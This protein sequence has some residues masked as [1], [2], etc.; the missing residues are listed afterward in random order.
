MKRRI[1]ATLLAGFILVSALPVTGAGA[2]QPESEQGHYHGDIKYEPWDGGDKRN[3]LPTDGKYYYL[4]NDIIRNANGS[5]VEITEEVAQHLCLNGHTITHCNPAKRLYDIEGEF[6]LEDCSENHEEGGI[7]YGGATPST[8]SFGNCFSIQRGGTMVMTGGQIF[9]F[10]SNLPAANNSVPIFVQGAD[11]TGRAVFSMLGG[12]I[13]SNSANADSAAIRLEK[14]MVNPATENLSQVNISGGKIWGNTGSCTIAANG[15]E[16]NITGG[17]ITGNYA[18]HSAVSVAG[19]CRLAICADVTIW[20]NQGGNLHLDG[21]T[22]I[23]LGVMTGGKIGIGASKTGRLISTPR[24]EDYSSFFASDDPELAVRYQ[25]NCLYLGASHIH[26]L[27]GG[28]ENINWIKWTDSSSLPT[29]TGNYYLTGDVQL[30]EMMLLPEDQQVNLCLNGKTVTAAQDRRIMTISKGAKLRITDCCDRW[31]TITGG[32]EEY[33]GAFY[34]LSGGELTLY[35]GIIT[36]NDA[37]KEGGAIYLQSNGGMFYMYGGEITGNTADRGGAVMMAGEN[38]QAYLYGGTIWGNTAQTDAGGVFV[39]TILGVQG[40]PVVKENKGNGRNSNIFLAQDA[41]I[42]AGKLENTAELFVSA[43]TAGRAITTALEDTAAASCFYS[44]SGNWQTET[45]GTLVYLFAVNRHDHCDCSGDAAACDHKLVSWYGWEDLNTLPEK[46]GWYYLTGDVILTSRMVVEAGSEIHLCLNGYTVTAPEN[47][48]LIQI[49]GEGRLVLTDCQSTGMLTG[50][51]KTFGGAVSVLCGGV[52]DMYGGKICDNTAG[53][54]KDG[55]GGAVYLQAGTTTETGGIA[56]IHGGELTG[57]SGYRGGAVYAD[58]YSRLLVNNVQITDN[59]AGNGG[60]VYMRNA[61]ADF[62]G[63]TL[64]G[65]KAEKSGGGLF[66]TDTDIH[67]GGTDI[68]NNEAGSNGGGVYI[69]DGT[70]AFTDG[71]FSN[72]T[73]GSHGGGWYLHDAYVTVEKAAVNGNFAK[74]G[75]GGIYAEGGKLTLQKD[76][77]IVSNSTE[78]SGGGVCATEL[79]QLTVDGAVFEKNIAKSGAGV[80]IGNGATAILNDPV[81]CQNQAGTGAGLYISSNVKVTVNNGQIKGNI[82]DNKGAGVCLHTAA[83]TNSGESELYLNG[84]AIQEN[85]A[86]KSG[87]G[88]YLDKRMKLVMDNCQVRN[89][90]AGGEGAGVFQNEDSA[91]SVKNTVLTGN[92]GKAAGS[93]LYTDGA[94]LLDGCTITGNMTTDGAAVHVASFRYKDGAYEDRS[95][96]LGGNLR[97]FENEGTRKGDLYFARGVK[98]CGTD[99]GFG[100]D[101]YI[102]IQIYSGVLTEVLLAAYDYEGSD[103]VYTITYGDRSLQKEEKKTEEKKTKEK[104]QKE[105]KEKEKEYNQTKEESQTAEKEKKQAKTESQTPEKEKTRAVVVELPS[106]EYSPLWWLPAF[107]GMCVLAGG[108]AVVLLLI[109]KK[110]EKK[111]KT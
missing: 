107:W 80:L 24:D 27:D 95:I 15:D 86:E 63:G 25:D 43:Q 19:D 67:F 28:T 89:N 45:D 68:K 92:A 51:N 12:Q 97:I 96:Q 18:K 75:S 9:G 66:V 59:T 37:A 110:S 79:C 6:Y 26:G 40:N 100:K 76:V 74:K 54:T 70:A 44:D 33:G 61:S 101:T 35:Q 36:G 103:R 42:A 69:T 32:R 111:N 85:V 104:E 81:I 109:K 106:P 8:N 78:E 48:R 13:H 84:T 4:T 30:T 71:E 14:A 90:T 17:V 21:D 34:V 94:L 52:L 41:V 57:N 20:D 53:L 83:R 22:I 77:Q 65:N 1:V 31:G 88:I 5:T 98:A 2:Q 55:L 99:E 10:C 72:N 39:P 108:C 3:A 82:A 73:S 105:T 56:H 38:A 16:L 23:H 50:G 29:E 102:Q 7:T 11:S 93:A 91:L 46:S 64:S 58:K 87:G 62:L 49:K 47:D 60:G